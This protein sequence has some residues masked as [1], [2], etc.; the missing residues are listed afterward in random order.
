MDEQEVEPPLTDD[1]ADSVHD[2]NQKLVRTWFSSEK[3]EPGSQLMSLEE[4][5][6]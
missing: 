4:I 2:C 1:K 5:L 6:N 3:L